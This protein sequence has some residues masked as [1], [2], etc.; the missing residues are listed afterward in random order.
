MAPCQS[1]G[2]KEDNTD[3]IMKHT[4]AGTKRRNDHVSSS[5]TRS[6]RLL[7]PKRHQEKTGISTAQNSPR[8]R[9]RKNTKCTPPRPG[10]DSKLNR[11]PQTLVKASNHGLSPLSTVNGGTAAQSL[12]YPL[13]SPKLT[14]MN[15]YTAKVL[16]KIDGGNKIDSLHH[17]LTLT[18]TSP[19]MT[20]QRPLPSGF[21]PNNCHQPGDPLI[22]KEVDMYPNNEDEDGDTNSGVSDDLMIGE[23][24]GVLKEKKSYPQNYKVDHILAHIRN[25]DVAESLLAESE[26]RDSEGLQLD[27]LES[28]KPGINRLS[29]ADEIESKDSDDRSFCGGLNS[30]GLDKRRRCRHMNAHKTQ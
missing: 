7:Q 8:A 19:P 24:E 27:G 18:P 15:A 6:N 26:E 22:G 2:N 21:V 12:S 25:D 16:P 1:T 3:S 29:K 20:H 9:K 23:I 17:L 4:E 14:C 28:E 10:T 11:L 5:P 13:H 30:E